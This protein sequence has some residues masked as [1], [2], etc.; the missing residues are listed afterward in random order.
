MAKDNESRLTA[1]TEEEQ[2][3]SDAEPMQGSEDKAAAVDVESLKQEIESL[4]AQSEHHLDQWKRAAAN[5]ENYRRR[6]EKERGDLLKAGQ[7]TLIAQLLPVLDDLERAFQTLPPTLRS[8]TWI[9][10]VALI[11]RKINMVLEQHG[12][13]EIEAFDQP[14]DPAR[15]QSILQEDTTDYP[16][17]HV[18]AVLQKGYQL[19]DKVLR[20]AMVKI[21][22]NERGSKRAS[23]A[24]QTE[25]ETAEAEAK[26]KSATAHQDSSNT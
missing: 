13:Q 8:L 3:G 10:G 6:V 11:E 12:L 7:A 18:M 2:S 16:D 22:V 15:H 21:A 23:N 1:S 26:G 9:D 4:K 19:H 5:L 24:Q 25:E 17:G 14:F 20:P